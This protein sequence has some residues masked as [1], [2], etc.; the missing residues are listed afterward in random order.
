M[1]EYRKSDTGVDG[2]M[3]E[4]MMSGKK[5]EGGKGGVEKGVQGWE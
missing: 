1:G 5:K 3:K 2:G 4:A